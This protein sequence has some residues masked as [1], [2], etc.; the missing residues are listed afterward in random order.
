ML[1][2]EQLKLLEGEN[3]KLGSGTSFIY[4]GVFGNNIEKIVEKLSVEEHKR[5]QN[6]KS[7]HTKYLLNFDRIWNARIKMK[8]K[9]FK[10]EKETNKKIKTTVEEYEEEL[11]IRREKEKIKVEKNLEE[12]TNQLK[13]FTPFLER[14]VIDV[15]ESIIDPE[16]KIVIF[17]GQEV[18]D[19][20]DEEEY[21]TGI[22]EVD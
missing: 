1:L 15:Y 8:I 13:V 12:V 16:V 11:I 21:K 14:E 3:V 5:L 22:K 18:G 7:R 17:E 10:K 19:Y 9:S 2:K 20:W 4:C 6:L